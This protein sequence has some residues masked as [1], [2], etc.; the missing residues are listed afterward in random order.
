MPQWVSALCLFLQTLGKKNKLRVYYL[1]WL[2]NKILRND[3]EVEKRQGW[4]SVGDLE[5]CVHY[6]VGKDS[7]FSSKSCSAIS[8]HPMAL[9]FSFSPV[10]GLDWTE[11]LQVLSDLP[12]NVADALLPIIPGSLSSCTATRWCSLWQLG[13]G[14]TSPDLLLSWC[15]R[16]SVVTEDF[17]WM[18]L[19][20][21]VLSCFLPGPE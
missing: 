6:K 19:S 13:E 21:P 5:G 4:V 12:V 9:V 14:S 18:V 17:G 16:H 20:T 2:R 1:S 3:P 8:L 15:F 11:Y 7:I 10:S